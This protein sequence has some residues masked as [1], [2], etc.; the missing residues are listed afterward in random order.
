MPRSAKR[1]SSVFDI[2][3]KVMAITE[4]ARRKW[5]ETEGEKAKPLVD[6]LLRGAPLR[7]IVEPEEIAAAV[8]LLASAAAAPII[9]GF[10]RTLIA[11]CVS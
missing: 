3:G 4:A 2:S 5:V 6:L 7:R 1:G 9:G 8:R 10:L 11:N